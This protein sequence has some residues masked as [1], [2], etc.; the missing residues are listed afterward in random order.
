RQHRRDRRR[1][2]TNMRRARSGL[3]MPALDTPRTVGRR[4]M[5]QAALGGVVGLALPAAAP[6]VAWADPVVTELR[7]D[8]TLLAGLGGNVLVRHAADGQVLVDSGAAEHAASLR[9]A[10]EQL[11]GAGRVAMLLNT[12]WH[13]DQ[14]GSN[15]ALG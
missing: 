1:L 7:D 8:F 12:H 5:L 9:A 15:D 6:R 13:P 3:C 10:L 14:V 2:S 4:S 11:P